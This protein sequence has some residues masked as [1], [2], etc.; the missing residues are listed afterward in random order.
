MNE[1]IHQLEKFRNQRYIFTD[2][3][4]AGKALGLMLQP[5]YDHIDE[6]VVLAIPSGGVPIGLSV[7][8]ILGLSFDMMIVRK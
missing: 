8:E 6:G 2:R 3:F 7:K 1:K 4:E 5:A